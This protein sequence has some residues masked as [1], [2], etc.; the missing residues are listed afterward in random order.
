MRSLRVRTA[1]ARL[2]GGIALTAG[3]AGVTAGASAPAQARVTGIV[4]QSHVMASWGDAW[5][6]DGTPG[7]SLYG[8]I[9][10]VG[11][12]VAQVSAGL[13]YHRLAVRSDGTVWAWGLNWFGQVGDGTTTNRATPV[14]VTGLVGL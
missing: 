12:N 2:A 11:N 13:G 6:G 3:M 4:F 1:L 14:Q 9:K 8:D 5:L 7:R 10:A